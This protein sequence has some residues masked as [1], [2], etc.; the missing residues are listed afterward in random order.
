MTSQMRWILAVLVSLAAAPAAAHDFW[1]RPS[2]FDALPGEMLDVGLYV[3]DG[4]QI[5]E[6]G[7]D[8]ALVLRFETIEG[9][10][11]RAIG[12]LPR[13]A[14]AGRARVDG[15]GLA[16]LVYQSRHSFV[17]LPADKFES[18]L[19]DEGLEEISFE[20]QR[21]GE[22]LAPS[23]ESYARYCKSLV[24]VGDASTEA[25][26][27]EIGLPIE[28]VAEGAPLAWHDG[29]AL[30]FRLLF[31]GAPLPGRLVKLVHLD[32]P[33]LRLFART[34]LEG[35]AAFVPPR[36][37]PW[38]AVAVHMLPATP[39]LEGDWESFWASLTFSLRE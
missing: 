7:R 36:G 32:M 2:T 17:E 6:L 12:G 18:Y 8:P 30:E 24:R 1:I 16:V 34:D 37:G 29:D 10:A 5:D 33:E 31:D 20:R 21:R 19:D 39:E 15:P 9:S 35:R 26:D 23:R 25:R 38:R 27:I 3:G 22:S 11:R 4:A 14:P 13:G 28:L